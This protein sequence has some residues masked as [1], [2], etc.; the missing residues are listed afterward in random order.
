MKRSLATPLLPSVTPW[1]LPRRQAALIVTNSSTT[2]IR[3][4][5][6]SEKTNIYAQGWLDIAARAWSNCCRRKQTNTGAGLQK[7]PDRSAL[8]WQKA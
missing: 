7:T 6:I 5:A 3:F 2:I 1:F 4:R 8:A